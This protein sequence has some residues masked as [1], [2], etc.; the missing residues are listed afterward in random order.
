MR[1][2]LRD[3]IGNGEA[4]EKAASHNGIT[5]ANYS[6]SFARSP[7]WWPADNPPHGREDTYAS[8][9]ALYA[10]FANIARNFYRLLVVRF[11]GR[12]VEVGS[13]CRRPE[14]GP[15]LPH[16]GRG[17]AIPIFTWV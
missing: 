3:S 16:L 17:M 6:D 5:L 9:L 4:Q 1:P 2:E 11:R 14:M 7:L 8:R 15:V 13:T 10:R 12:S